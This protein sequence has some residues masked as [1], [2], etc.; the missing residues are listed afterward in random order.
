MFLQGQIM[1][2]LVNPYPTKL[3]VHKSHDVE[4]IG[5]LFI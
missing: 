1:Y 5:Q 3:W 4:G 2:Y